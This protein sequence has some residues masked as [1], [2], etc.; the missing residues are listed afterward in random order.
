MVVGTAIPRRRIGDVG[1]PNAY[2]MRRGLAPWLLVAT[3]A[4]TFTVALTALTA[5]D[6]PREASALGETITATFYVPLYEDNAR[7][8]LFGTNSGIRPHRL[9]PE[10]ILDFD[11]ANGVDRDIAAHHVGHPGNQ[12]DLAVQPLQT[13]DDRQPF[14]PAGRGNGQ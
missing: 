13:V 9:A 14:R 11:L 8:A 10:Q 3:L 4:S 12:L 6:A 7:A 1:M 2:R 5:V